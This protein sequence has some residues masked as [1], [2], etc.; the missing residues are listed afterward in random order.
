[1]KCLEKLFYERSLDFDINMK[2]DLMRME[3]EGSIQLWLLFKKEF[4]KAVKRKR[5][6]RLFQAERA[7][8]VFE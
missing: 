1:M 3:E 5:L 4:L 6:F 8:K 7:R 2:Y